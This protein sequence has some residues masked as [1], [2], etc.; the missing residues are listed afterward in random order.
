MP[1]T[2]SASGSTIWPD[3]RED[4]GRWNTPSIR[5]RHRRP[6]DRADKRRLPSTTRRCLVLV[7]C[8]S[9]FYRAFH[10]LP[11]LT[12][13]K[14]RP[15]GAAYGMTNMLKRLE[16]HDSLVELC[17]R[18]EIPLAPVLSRVERNGVRVDV[19][20]GDNWDEAH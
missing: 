11:A 14:G 5:H 16:A 17:N 2:P 18:V 15:T 19:G 4:E 9:Y 13:S 8:S 1:P 7:D 3:P 12:N 6:A 10:A 20:V